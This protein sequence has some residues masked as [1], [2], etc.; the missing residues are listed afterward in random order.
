M[1]SLTCTYPDLPKHH[2]PHQR[3]ASLFLKTYKLDHELSDDEITKRLEPVFQEGKTVLWTRQLEVKIYDE[4][5][6][7]PADVVYRSC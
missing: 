5:N 1:L 4:D 7:Y 6:D 3:L 2:H